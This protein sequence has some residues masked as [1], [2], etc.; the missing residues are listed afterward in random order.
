MS[1]LYGFIGGVVFTLVAA[2][3]YTYWQ[4]KQYKKNPKKTEDK[5]KKR[6]ESL[7]Y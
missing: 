4:I 3:L 2:F 5:I 1:F 7:G 6:M